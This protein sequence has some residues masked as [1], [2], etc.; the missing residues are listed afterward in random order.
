MSSH[1]SRRLRK[2]RGTRLRTK[3]VALL[4]SLT[5][6]WAFAAFVTLREGLNLLWV[7]TLTD[8]V[9]RP[10]ESLLAAL[11]QERRLSV[12]YA[13]DA[14]DRSEQTQSLRAQRARTDEDLAA[15]R[16]RTHDAKVSWAA[17]DGLQGRIKDLTALLDDL[18][19][20]RAALD[21]NR[22]GSP[23]AVASVYTDIIDAGFRVYGSIAA[24]DDPDIAKQ[25]R[26]LVA[27]SRARETLSQEDALLA[28][29]LA[30]G[31]FSGAEH[32]QFVELVG[33]QR[34]AYAEAAAELP[35]PERDQYNQLSTG[36]ALSTLRT[37][38]DRVV[39]TGQ[40]GSPA[41][42]DAATWASAIQAA[43][44]ELRSLELS[45]ADLTLQRAEPAAITV[46][47]RL[48]LAGVLGLIAVIASIVITITTARSL[49]RQ[50]VQLRDA[51]QILAHERLPRVVE[52]LRQGETV[53]VDAQAPPL[54]FGNDEIGQV[55]Q[56][57]NAVQRTAIHAAVE[58]A[59]LRKSVRDV[60]VSLARRTQTL[61]H[62]Q[63]KLLDGMERH[64][65][66]ADELAV[67]FRV[68]HLATRMRRNAENL[69]VLSG[70]VS[71]R[72]WRH[73]VAMIDIVRG[74]VAEIEDYA[75]VT[76]LPIAPA[77]LAGRVV[78]DVIH[79]LAELI[80]NAARFSP[81]H[82]PV[83][84]GGQPVAN[85]FVVEIEDRGL[86]MSDE[87][88]EAANAQ[89]RNPPEF[90]L[91][92]TARLGLYVVGRIA[93][94]HGIGIHLRRSPYGGTTA[95]VL[96][97]PALI[98][99]QTDDR[100]ALPEGARTLAANGRRRAADPLSDLSDRF[101]GLAPASGPGPGQ[102]SAWPPIG[103]STQ[104]V[105]RP[106]AVAATA[107]PLVKA[108]SGAE[109]PEAD[110]ACVPM[111][112]HGLPRRR[113]RTEPPETNQPPEPVP[114]T[115]NGAGKTR[116]PE[117]VR[118]LMSAYQQ[119]T[120]RARYDASPPQPQPQPP[121]PPQPPVPAQ[122]G[123][124]AMPGPRPNPSPALA[125][126]AGAPA[127]EAAPSMARPHDDQS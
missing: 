13:A 34:F 48:L 56:A 127:V 67:L 28:G 71:G 58:Q 70:A 47:A 101:A 57:F 8:S 24:L 79:L 52:H 54:E 63:L 95:I 115:P 7:S 25:S 111:T 15:F 61:V 99:E 124:R 19:R 51:A 74:A 118:D 43:A 32:A 62:R 50:L 82:T 93:E 53:D 23:A 42:V 81:P 121:Q 2:S 72:G 112:I 77:G 3:V 96:I 41:P 16:R 90:H 21:A 110:A 1:S 18:P 59:E 108:A 113:R 66:D 104:T 9:G 20:Q 26:T 45:S 22:I 4:L 98:V 30:A 83:Q 123:P 88:L 80:E 29:V 94:R 60:F 84:V 106:A 119:G 68:D 17:S 27:L 102:P 76:V 69:I 91:S 36:V 64:E 97:P 49:V 55:G 114:A 6:L 103:L 87:S 46:I 100:Q 5:A 85:G 126:P 86:G 120:L 38:E 37:I 122:S 65:T 14:A 116:S 33:V 73:P 11:Q 92:S 39:N 12:V 107:T 78:G 31:Q 35:S 117:E 10:T 75:R 44:S 105:D 109:P 40:T 89:L 125:E